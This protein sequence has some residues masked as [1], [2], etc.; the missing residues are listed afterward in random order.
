MSKKVKFTAEDE[1]KIIDFV[2]SNEIIYN[3]KHKKFRD[4][5]SKNR[6]WLTVANDL[7]IEGLYFHMNVFSISLIPLLLIELYGS[8]RSGEKEMANDAGLLRSFERKENNWFCGIN[9]IKKG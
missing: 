3:V 1:E 9:N 6:L 5:E 4:T 8:S 2:K 7:G